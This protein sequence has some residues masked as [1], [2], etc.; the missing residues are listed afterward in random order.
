MLF[1]NGERGGVLLSFRRDKADLYQ[2]QK[3]AGLMRNGEEMTHRISGNPFA[4]SECYL[5]E[6]QEP[7]FMRWWKD[8]SVADCEHGDLSSWMGTRLAGAQPNRRVNTRRPRLR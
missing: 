5:L 8:A 7:L 3:F 4:C 6:A 2:H 1:S